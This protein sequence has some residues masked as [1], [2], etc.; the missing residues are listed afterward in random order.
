GSGST[1]GTYNFNLPT[2]A[3]SSGGPLLS[4]GGGAAAMTWGTASGSTT[5]FGTV[6][7]SLTNGNCIAA[8]A[9][10]NLIDNGTPCGSGGSGTVTSSTAGQVAYYASSTNAVAGNSSLTISGG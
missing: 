2:T 8:D 10:G 3:G 1:V 7:G 6:T 5:K 4:G 9:S